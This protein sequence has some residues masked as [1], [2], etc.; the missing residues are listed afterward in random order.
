MFNGI[1]QLVIQIHQP[2][3]SHWR[4]RIPGHLEWLMLNGHRTNFRTTTNTS[5]AIKDIEQAVQEQV[6]SRS[7]QGPEDLDNGAKDIQRI[8]R[9]I[10]ENYK[11]AETEM[12]EIEKSY[13]RQAILAEITR[14]LKATL[15]RTGRQDEH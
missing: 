3:S 11:T 10:I 9:S 8:A 14:H 5:I 2:G 4:Q 7:I 15:M 6:N 13:Y 12:T 1:D